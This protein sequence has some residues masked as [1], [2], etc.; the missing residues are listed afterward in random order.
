MGPVPSRDELR[1]QMVKDGL[2]GWVATPRAN[3][4]DH[5]R[6][7]ADGDPH[8]QLGLDFG[9]RWPY[10]RVLAV[11]AERSGRVPDTTAPDGPDFIDPDVTVDALDRLA[12]SLRRARGRRVVV[13]TGH[14]SGLLETHAAIARGLAAAGAEI[15]TVPAGLSH[16]D[17]RVDQFE[18]VAAV[19]S[20]GSLRH[21]HS[22]VWMG[23]VLDALVASGRP[24]PELVVADHGWAGCAGQRG[25]ETVCFA[26]CNDPA[27]FVGESEGTIAVTVPLDDA[28]PFAAYR[29][30]IAYVLAVAF[31]AE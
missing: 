9:G 13:A 17:A 31:G 27:L 3:S 23:L 11:M 14:P 15:V 5:F 22:P 24:L 12:A 16:G 18:G 10:E 29:P 19:I 21:T 20:G 7:L 30:M 4:L 8:F 28:L 6:R 25:I 2:A 1:E 26:D